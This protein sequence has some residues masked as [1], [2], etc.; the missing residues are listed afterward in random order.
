MTISA[1]VTTSELKSAL[2]QVTTLELESALERY[3]SALND[4]DKTKP[5]LSEQTVL[6]VLVARDGVFEAISEKTTASTDCLTKLVELDNR[7]KEQT[8][9]NKR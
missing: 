2:E 9:R 7:L 6:E 3:A 4:I 5:D 8:E 1:K